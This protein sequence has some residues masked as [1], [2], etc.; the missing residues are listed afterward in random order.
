MKRISG[1][2]LLLALVS[3]ACV[4]KSESEARARA[5]FMA[6]QQKATSHDLS[7]KL[8]VS[9]RGDVKKTTIPWEEELTLAKA[10]L[11]AEYTG[12]WDPHTI[13]IIRKG[14]IYRINPRQL[15]SGVME[16]PVLE[17]GDIVEVHR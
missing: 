16:D 8:I 2:C 7:Q 3:S 13:S 17:P 9:F 10:L 6:G 1:W 5:A 14:Q 12:L 11:T 15:L 4:S